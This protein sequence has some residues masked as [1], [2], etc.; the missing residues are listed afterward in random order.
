MMTTDDPNLRRP[1]DSS[2]INLNQEHEV[3]WWTKEFGRT[4]EQLQKAVQAVGVS[5]DK[6]RDYLR[7][8]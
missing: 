5:A 3:R 7:R 2:R 8:K 1:Q 6:V 4:R